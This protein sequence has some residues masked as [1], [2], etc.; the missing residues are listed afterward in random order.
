[1]EVKVEGLAELRDLLQRKLPYEIQTKAL[2]STLAKAAQ[3]I[4]KDARSRVPVK[5][6]R[7]RR[8]I[9]SFRD[10]AS[11][12]VKAIRLISVRSGRRHGGK[13]AFYWKW[14][15]FGRGESKVGKKRGAPRGGARAASLGTPERGWFGK[16]VKAVAARPFMRPAFESRK[17]EALE[18]FRK[19]MATEIQ[20]TAQRL[21]SRTVSRIKRSVGLR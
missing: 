20:K 15:E 1:M 10:K 4:L 12:K 7:L 14:V 8:A 16:K 21:Q 3:P 9:Y 11:T 2:Q 17:M 5:S 6:G 13:D 19:N 18:T